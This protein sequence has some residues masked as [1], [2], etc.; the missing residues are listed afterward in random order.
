MRLKGVLLLLIIHHLTCLGQSKQLLIPSEN[1]TFL[2]VTEF[3]TC[4]QGDSILTAKYESGTIAYHYKLNN[5]YPSGLYKTYHPNGQVYTESVWINKKLNGIWK[6]YDSNGTLLE[7]GQYIDG[8]RSGIW[9]IFYKGNVEVYKKG[10]K[11]GRWRINEGWSPKTL[12]RYKKGVL[13]KVKRH[14][15]K[16]NIFH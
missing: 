9:F 4:Q 5:S 13:N 8:L 3:I 1:G 14:Y 6:R 10:R 16:K 15:P 2:K 7:S 11:R 12:Y